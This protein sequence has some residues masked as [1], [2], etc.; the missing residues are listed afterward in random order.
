MIYWF[1][2]ATTQSVTELVAELVAAQTG[3]LTESIRVTP[4]YQETGS[5]LLNRVRHEQL[6]DIRV[7]PPKQ[8]ARTMVICYPNWYNALPVAVTGFLEL[9]A[10]TASDIYPVCVH[11]GSGLGKTV[12]QIRE[13]CG[14][15][16]IH[17]GLPIR[18]TRVP[19]VATAIEVWAAENGL[20]MNRSELND[21]K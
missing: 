8:S 17:P 21:E 20:N 14:H 3:Q 10:A 7:T 6:E 1:T 13:Q 4:A 9:V 19:K 12:D 2:A 15:A 5:A 16:H 11:T 18:A